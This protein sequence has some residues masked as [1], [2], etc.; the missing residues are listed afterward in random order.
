M[1]MRYDKQIVVRCSGK[2][3]RAIEA[4][5]RQNHAKPGEVTRRVLEV[6]FGVEEEL[7]LPPGLTKVKPTQ[8]APG[9][10]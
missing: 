2:L 8:G 6:A 4:W 9:K 1:A 7:P 10:A 3:Y 5:A